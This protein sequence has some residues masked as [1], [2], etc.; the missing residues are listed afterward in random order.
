[1][2][3][4]GFS[5]D[6]ANR[7]AT[8][9]LSDGQIG[10]SYDGDGLLIGR[11]SGKERLAF[12]NDVLA[13]AWTPVM[14][15]DARGHDRFFLW[16]Q[17]VPLAIVDGGIPQFLLSDHVGSVRLLSGQQGTAMQRLGYDPFGLPSNP[18]RPD[19]I[20]FGYGGM[21]FDND[22]GLY[23]TRFRA[24]DPELGRFL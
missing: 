11:T 5:F 17:D 2:G 7:L 6:T 12:V 1:R 23:L 22:A 21:L 19:S 24:Y 13:S 15:R 20:S 10:Y 4:V 18:T 16:E 14:S 3:K 9:K 8:A